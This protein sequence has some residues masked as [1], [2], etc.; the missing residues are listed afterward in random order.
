M[1]ILLSDAVSLDAQHQRYRR[2]FAL[3]RDFRKTAVVVGSVVASE[4]GL[5]YALKTVKPADVGGVAGGQKYFC[6]GV[7]L[8]RVMDDMGIYGGLDG[9]MKAAGHELKGLRAFLLHS[10]EE[11][12]EKRN[13]RLLAQ[14]QQQ[15]AGSGG[16][17]LSLASLGGGSGSSSNN[18]GVM[19]AAEER[20]FSGLMLVLDTRGVRMLATTL[21]PVGKTSLQYGSADAGRTV[22][23]HPRCHALMERAA[24]TINIKAHKGVCRRG[25]CGRVRAR[26]C[27]SVCLCVSVRVWY[28]AVARCRVVCCSRALRED[29]PSHFLASDLSCVT[30]LRMCMC[31]CMCSCVCVCVCVRARARGRAGVAWAGGRGVALRG[32]AVGPAHA[33]KEI[34][35]PCDIECHIGSDDR[36][37]VLDT[38]RVFPPAPPPQT[39][40]ICIIP[41]TG[42]I[43]CAS[44]TYGLPD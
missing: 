15:Q 13:K 32:V 26:H 24:R 10:L 1:E 4:V 30:H 34:Y 17:G 31:T 33:L 41:V 3:V 29:N 20:L 5:P 40:N 14:Q 7:F 8:K 22:H 16:A 21:L 25:A 18:V 12:K 2:L 37:Y 28:R 11:E 35:G 42:A 19:S 6:R 44:G 43:K 38:A 39:F 36:V 27:L 23:A 9:A